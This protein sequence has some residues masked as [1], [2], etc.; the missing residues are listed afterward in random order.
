LK[1]EALDRTMWRNRFGRGFG[2][3]VWQI[4]DDDDDKQR[5]FCCPKLQFIPRRNLKNKRKYEKKAVQNNKT[6]SGLSSESILNKACRMYLCMLLFC[7][8]TRTVHLL[9]FCTMNNK[10]TNIS[11]IITNLRVSTLFCHPQGAFN[12]YLAKLHK[13]FKWSFW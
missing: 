1:E 9:L 10:C 11:Q 6:L 4:T 12:N 5:Q 7:F 13:Y 2:P 8:N 3:V